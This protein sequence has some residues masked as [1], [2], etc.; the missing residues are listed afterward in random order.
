MDD[1]IV[2]IK[3]TAIRF[4]DNTK[5]WLT[6]FSTAMMA[7][8]LMSGYICDQTWPYYTAIGLVGAHL[9]QQITSLKIY[10]P[11]DCARKFLSNYQVGLLIFVGIILGNYLKS[12]NECKS[13]TNRQ[14]SSTFMKM[15]VT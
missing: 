7:G 5:E 6:A 2:G 3:S 9:A 15:H 10:D 13:T 8:L 12:Q 14:H 11:G 1:L 4:G